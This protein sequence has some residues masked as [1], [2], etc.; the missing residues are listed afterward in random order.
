MM[1][2][3]R[4]KQATGPNIRCRGPLLFSLVPFLIATVATA[5]DRSP[6][7][8]FE[9]GLGGLLAPAYEGAKTYKVSPSPIFHFGYLA[10][11]NGF[12]LGG[13]KQDGLSFRPSV[14]FRAKR[15]SSD[16]AEING[17]RDVG[18]SLELGGGVAY[19]VAN[20]RGFADLRYGVTGHKGI[21]GEAGLDV[22]AKP[23][24]KLSVYGG[25]RVSFANTRYMDSYFSVTPAES[26][27]SGLAAFSAKGGLKSVGVEI[28][29]RYQHD[30]N[31]AVESAATWNRLVADAGKSPVAIAGSRDQ[32]TV[33]LGLVRKFHIGF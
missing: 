13:G 4:S 22:L 14:N 18:A 20:F 1:H 2:A 3:L 9:I 31:W 10:L 7:I 26:V 32:F 30:D 16:Y 29:G 15:K 17:L 28:G 21:V 19:T 27:A 8:E 12:V 25:P 33:K 11:P 5:Q 6:G 23:M 24:D